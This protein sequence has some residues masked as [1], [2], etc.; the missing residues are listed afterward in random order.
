MQMRMQ[1]TGDGHHE[2]GFRI[3]DPGTANSVRRQT[4]RAGGSCWRTR[5]VATPRNIPTHSRW[6]YAVPGEA[7]PTIGNPDFPPLQLLPF[8]PQHSHRFAYVHASNSC[9]TH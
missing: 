9:T 2:S 6:N 1:G 4:L 8:D 3:Q 5:K 7:I